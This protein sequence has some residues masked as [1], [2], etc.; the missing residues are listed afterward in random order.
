MD[1][2]S[3]IEAY[4]DFHKDAYGF[5]PRFDYT[6][7]S[8]EKL[9]ADFETFGRDLE[10]RNLREAEAEAQAIFDWEKSI[11]DA[12]ALGAADED[13]ATRWLVGTEFDF[14]GV[15]HKQDIE[16]FVWNQGFLF[17]DYG[18]QLVKKI[19]CLVTQSMKINF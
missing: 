1:R 19:E 2:E 16:Q 14:N 10:S 13:E 6:L 7:L 5:R 11:H 15:Y 4:S 17:T 9:A 18:R 3:M 12:I 8:T